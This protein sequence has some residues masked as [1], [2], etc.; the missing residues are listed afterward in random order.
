MS[1]EYVIEVWGD[2]IRVKGVVPSND[3]KAIHMLAKT[4]G[5][6]V[7]DLL[8]GKHYGVTLFFTSDALSRQMQKE[9]HG[10]ENS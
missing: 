8:M 10:K 1:A 9:L 2:S 6:D 4:N 3:L 5:Y 7:I